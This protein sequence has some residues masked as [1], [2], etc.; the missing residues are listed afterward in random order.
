MAR[1]PKPRLDVN[2]PKNATVL[3][4]AEQVRAEVRKRYGAD[5][6]YEQRRD[7][8]AK[9]MAEVLWADGDK[10]LK[11]QATNEDEVESMAGAT[12][13]SSR[14]L[15]RSTTDAGDRTRLKSRST[16]RSAFTTGQRSNRSNAEW[17]W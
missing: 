6:T 7:A 15:Q 13:S 4:L 5:L 9:V 11:E 3:K 1:K 8:A 2:D 14:R 17:G 10:D 12:G 16:G